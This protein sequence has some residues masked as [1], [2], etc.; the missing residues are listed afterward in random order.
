MPSFQQMP[1]PISSLLAGFDPERILAEVRDRYSE[2]GAAPDAEHPFRVGRNFAVALGYPPEL[3]D[4]LP[5]CCSE[6]FTGVAHSALLAD[7]NAGDVVVDLGCGG[8]L[9][10]LLLSRA[11]GSR[12]SV[13]GVDFAPAMVERAR[14]S[15][16][17]AGAS[18]ASV[19]EESAS[20]TG[21]QDQL[22]DCV[23]AN[24]I[25]NLSPDKAAIVREIARILKPGGRFYLAEITL[26]SAAPADEVITIDDWFR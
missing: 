23:V 15:V 16:R 24:G 26:A 7:V 1:S 11:V 10:L 19:V 6:A 3:L 4:Q 12:G 25:L 2:V 18:N 5:A 9:D 17:L 8:G 20:A 21:L 22:A 13:I 14:Q